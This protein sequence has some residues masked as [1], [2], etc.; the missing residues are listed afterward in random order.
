MIKLLN[1]CFSPSDIP[2]SLKKHTLCASLNALHGHFYLSWTGDIRFDHPLRVKVFHPYL[3]VE[4][5]VGHRFAGHPYRQRAATG[6]DHHLIALVNHLGLL[7]RHGGD[8]LIDD[9]LS[10]NLLTD[11]LIK[12]CQKSLAQAADIPLTQRDI[13]F[14][15]DGIMF[16]RSHDRDHVAEQPHLGGHEHCPGRR[17]L[18]THPHGDPANRA[19]AFQRGCQILVAGT[20]P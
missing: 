7:K 12:R 4:T 8:D 13:F 19:R 2:R 6:D 9:H 14:A 10:D 3:F 17:A 20:H 18:A 16:Q 1:R 15:H 5:A 11:C